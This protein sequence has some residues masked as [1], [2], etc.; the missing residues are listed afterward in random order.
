MR[1]VSRCSRRSRY[2]RSSSVSCAR[3]PRRAAA[4][5]PARVQGLVACI[6]ILAVTAAYIL[7]CQ[8][9]LTE[10][11]AQV[12]EQNDMLNELTAEN[13]S[14]TTKRG[15][16]PGYD[17]GGGIRNEYA[18]YGK[19]GQFADRICFA[20]Q[21]GYRYGWRRAAFHWMRFSAVWRAVFPRSWNIS[22]EQMNRMRT[23][24]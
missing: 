11:T 5:R 9:Q 1:N 16:Q 4:K 6:A 10:L 15:E 23:G 19:D 12:S 8:M 21:P 20:H 14:L 24:E 3:H 18:G 17:R 2:S 7:F 13:V 22:T